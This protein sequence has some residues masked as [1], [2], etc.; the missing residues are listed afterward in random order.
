MVSAPTIRDDA[1]LAEGEARYFQSLD[2]AW[3][4]FVQDRGGLHGVDLTWRRDIGAFESDWDGLWKGQYG[5][6]IGLVYE[7]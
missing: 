3:A 2:E 1:I 4:R 7:I 5:P 6:E